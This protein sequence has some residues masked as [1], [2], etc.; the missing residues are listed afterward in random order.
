MKPKNTTSTKHSRRFDQVM[1]CHHGELCAILHN[2][3]SSLLPLVLRFCEKDII[4]KRTKNKIDHQN[5][6]EGANI[7]MKY[8]RM[9][10]EHSPNILQTVLEVMGEVDVLERVI[11]K[12]KE[13]IYVPVES[14]GMV[15]MTVYNTEIYMLKNGVI[16]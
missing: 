1:R 6:Y 9:K 12:M 3:D 10:V 16:D 5:Q 13:E 11:E 7:M 15:N 4:D 8:L 14:E 2:D